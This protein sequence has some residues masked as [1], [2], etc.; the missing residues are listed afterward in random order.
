[1]PQRLEW[2]IDVNAPL[3]TIQT[4]TL[5]MQGDDQA[6]TL[7][8]RV[9]SKGKAYDLSGYTAS[10]WLERRDGVRVPVDG[11]VDGNTVEVTLTESCYRVSGRY[12][13]FVR[14]TNAET[15]EKRTILRVT[16][17]M[18]SEGNGPVLDEEDT[19]PSIEDIVAQLEIMEKATASA[20]AAANNANKAAQDAVDTAQAAANNANGVAQAVQDKLDSGEL[21]GKGLQ[22]LGYYDTADALAA[23]VTNPEA[24]DAYGVGTAEP[25]DIY[26]WDA[27]HAVWV[28]NGAIQGPQGE[29]GPQ[30]PQGEPGADG[31][32]G[33]GAQLNLLDNSNFRNPVNQR[34]IAQGVTRDVGY[35]IDRWRYDIYGTASDAYFGIVADAYISLKPPADGYSEL[36][37]NLECYDRIKGSTCT[38][39]MAAVYKGEK[40]TLAAVFQMGKVPDGIDLTE[41]GNV[42]L[43]SIDSMNITIRV[44]GDSIAQEELAISWAALYEGEYTADTLPPYIPKGYAVELL[45]CQRYYYVPAGAANMAYAGYTA[46]AANARI[47]V[48]TPVPMRTTPSIVVETIGNVQVYASDGAHNA[49]G[50]TVL[51]LQGDCVALQIVTSGLTTWTPCTMRFNT[52]VALSADL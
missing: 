44:H 48:P 9:T 33:A 22:I 32:N 41:D 27:L 25:Y 12:I 24:G 1:M 6:N 34:G 43:Y 18:E 46:S 50:V 13:A 3:N 5:M 45:E 42:K 23:G 8:V 31:R 37:Q 7:A 39:T 14:I 20:N 40:Q 47:T 36:C 29:T 28:N 51:Q 11:T 21:V 4:P 19:I 15:G 30:G 10:A 2:T 52:S 17:M 38:L 49:T 35:K 16:G 26:V